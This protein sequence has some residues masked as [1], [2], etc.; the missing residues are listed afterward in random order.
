MKFKFYQLEVDNFRVDWTAGDELS[1]LF[2][3][4]YPRQAKPI[5]GLAL[6]QT[7]LPARATGSF[8]AIQTNS[9]F[10]WDP[11]TLMAPGISTGFASLAGLS[12]KWR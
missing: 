1:S 4:V 3:F 5:R 7:F 9:E 6:G 8:L 12:I 2:D 10:L 11:G